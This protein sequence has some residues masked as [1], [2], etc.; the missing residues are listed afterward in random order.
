LKQINVK[1]CGLTTPDMVEV[2]CAAGAS[3]V[4]FVLS[5]SP[6]QVTAR[7]AHD[8]AECA[9]GNVHRVAVFKRATPEMLAQIDALGEIT[10]VQ[11]DW[12]DE[13][14]VRE[15]APRVSFVPV[16]RDVPTLRVELAEEETKMP[17]LVLIEGAISGI[18]MLPDWGRIARATTHLS[19]EFMLAGGLTP[20]NV[21]RAISATGASWVDVSSGVETRPG[22]KSAELIARFVHEAGLG[23][24]ERALV[25]NKRR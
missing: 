12:Q 2:A 3:A 21:A 9:G 13:A 4:G 25:K 17:R 23:F 18:G 22:E 14:M 7:V 1:I 11:A 24:R 15:F 6:R 5:S 8:L 20:D 16:F 10:H 19:R